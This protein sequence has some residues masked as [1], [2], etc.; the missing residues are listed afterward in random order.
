MVESPL[1]RGAMALLRLQNWE[2]GSHRDGENGLSE[3]A[4]NVTAIFGPT[5]PRQDSYKVY[6]PVD[7]LRRWMVM[8]TRTRIDRV[9]VRISVNK[10]LKAGHTTAVMAG[11]EMKLASSFL[12]L[13]GLM[14][15]K[16]PQ[17]AFV[18]SRGKNCIP[19]LEQCKGRLALKPAKAARLR[20]LEQGVAKDVCFRYGELRPLAPNLVPIRYSTVVPSIRQTHLYQ[21]QVLW[22]CSDSPFCSYLL[23]TSFL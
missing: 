14:R 7:A 20:S 11:D 15:W 23:L 9:N 22:Y 4:R 8:V 16:L 21:F 13:E 6:Q 3:E 17:T 2:L 18:R 19:R 10:H 5:P 12:G 1:R